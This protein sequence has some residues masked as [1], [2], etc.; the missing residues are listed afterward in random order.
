MRA[1]PPAPRA[2]PAKGRTTTTRVAMHASTSST[3]RSECARN[4]CRQPSRLWAIRSAPKPFVGLDRCAR[5]VQPAI[6]RQTVLP[7]PWAPSASVVTAQSARW[8]GRLQ[9]N[10]S[11]RASNALQGKCRTRTGLDAHPAAGTGTLPSATIVIRVLFHPSSTR[12]GQY[13]ALPSRP[14]AVVWLKHFRLEVH[15]LCRH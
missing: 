9:T 2:R 3:A 5:K 11:L 4:V 10:C 7:A 13:A 6:S 15:R 1:E 14:W 12:S 8:M